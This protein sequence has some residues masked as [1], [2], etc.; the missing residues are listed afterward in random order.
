[1]G[2]IWNTWKEELAVAYCWCFGLG[3][4]PWPR[5]EMMMMKRKKLVVVAS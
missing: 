2:L 1:M 3:W 5:V 4:I